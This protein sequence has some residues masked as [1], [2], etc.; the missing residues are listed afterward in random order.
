MDYNNI[1]CFV[2]RTIVDNRTTKTVQLTRQFRQPP[3]FLSV[4]LYKQN[5]ASGN[6]HKT[7]SFR[8]HTRRRPNTWK[9][10]YGFSRRGDEGERDGAS[11]GGKERK[12]EKLRVFIS[13]P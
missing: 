10:P 9:N 11:G 13:A 1:F 8:P 12:R 7:K 4:Q 2:F 3:Y 5:I 6:K